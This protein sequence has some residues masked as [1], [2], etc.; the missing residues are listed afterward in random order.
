[1]VSKRTS[2][3]WTRVKSGFPATVT[4]ISILRGVFGPNIGNVTSIIFN[5]LIIYLCLKV[6]KWLFTTYK[7]QI[8]ASTSCQISCPSNNTTN[9]IFFI[10]INLIPPG[11]INNSTLIYHLLIFTT[12]YRSCKIFCKNCYNSRLIGLLYS[13][14]GFTEYYITNKYYIWSI[15]NSS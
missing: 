5:F 11:S 1:M 3:W 9:T 6:D 7:L 10:I 4:G 8:A 14:L 2:P 12:Y 13:C 15:K